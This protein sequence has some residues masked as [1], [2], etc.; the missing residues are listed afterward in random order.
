MAQANANVERSSWRSRRAWVALLAVTLVGLAVDLGT[1]VWAF[2]TVAGAPVI[3]ERETVLEVMRT[4][5]P[6]AISRLIPAHEPVTVVPSVLD[7]VLVLNPGAVFGIGP[8]QRG[9]FLVFTVL[10]LGGGLL[11]FAKGTRARDWHAHVAIGLLLSGGLGNLYDRLVFG[12]VRDFIHPLPGVKFPFGLKLWSS[13]GEV[14][15]YVSNV[16]DAFLIAGI[17]VLMVYLWRSGH[18]APAQPAAGQP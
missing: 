11:L 7:F 5:S 14:W 3:V 15:P 10:A 12:C 13:T 18:G 16:A 2:R 1:K 4:Q 6:R 9:F 17:G 8:G